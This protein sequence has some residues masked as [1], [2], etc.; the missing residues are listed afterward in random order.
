[1]QSKVPVLIGGGGKRVLVLAAREADIV[2]NSRRIFA[3]AGLA[4]DDALA[5]R[6]LAVHRST[7]ARA[8]AVPFADVVDDVFRHVVRSQL[9]ELRVPTVIVSGA[10]DVVVPPEACAQA[11]RQVGARFV[12]LEGVGHCPHLEAP[13]RVADIVRDVLA[14]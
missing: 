11:A 1:M 6:K 14:A 10:R 7:Q 3:T 5:A 12:S 2:G 13:D 8:F 4:I 9:P